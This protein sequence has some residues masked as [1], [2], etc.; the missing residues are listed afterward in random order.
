MKTTEEIRL[1]LDRI[2][3]DMSDLRIRKRRLQSEDRALREQE[4][5]LVPYETMLREIKQY[6]ENAGKPGRLGQF[7]GFYAKFGASDWVKVRLTKKNGEVGLR[8]T[9]FYKWIKEE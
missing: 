3:S 5:G 9:T 1:E 8:E 2:D 6:S 4:N 7:L